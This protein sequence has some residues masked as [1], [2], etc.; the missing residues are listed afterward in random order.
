MSRLTL[1]LVDIH[2]HYDNKEVL[3]GCSYVFEPG[4]IYAIIGPNGSGKSTLLRI[5]ALLEPPGGGRV[6]YTDGDKHIPQDLS[7][8]RRIGLLLPGGG[9]FNTSVF[10]NA[11]YGLKIRGYSTDVIN[12]RVSSALKDVGLWQKRHQNALTLSTG[13][14]QRLALVRTVVTLPEVLML[15]EPTN[16]LDPA[17]TLIIE[18]MIRKIMGTS[19]PTIIMV[20]HNIFQ[21]RRLAD[22]VLFM[23][24][25]RII[26]EGRGKEFFDNPPIQDRKIWEFVTGQY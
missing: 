23:Y 22:V 2:K 21:A 9:L 4:R 26:A 5:G 7:L 16:S 18:E 17:S 14:A 25:G 1:S 24:E 19:S 3:R 10:K 6:I 13:E 11:A 12:D 20:T 8:R 15:D